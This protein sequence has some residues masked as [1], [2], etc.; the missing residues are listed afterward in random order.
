MKKEEDYELLQVIGKNLCG[1]NEDVNIDISFY[2]SVITVIFLNL[3]FTYKH[4]IV[5][6][7]DITD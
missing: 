7:V 4:L 2:I 3:L 1:D 6:Q 5:Y